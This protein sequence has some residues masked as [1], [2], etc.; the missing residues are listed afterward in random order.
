VLA[1]SHPWSTAIGEAWPKR[2]SWRPLA[3]GLPV[4]PGEAWPKR[5]SWRPPAPGLPVEVRLAGVRHRPAAGA[6]H[7]PV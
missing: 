2:A 5:A 6:R 7:G 4:E 1:I 3:P